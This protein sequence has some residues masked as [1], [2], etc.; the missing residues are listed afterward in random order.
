MI[1]ANEGSPLLED[2]QSV[3]YMILVNAECP[4]AVYRPESVAA[5]V[6]M[7][8]PFPHPTSLVRP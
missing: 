7:H 2:F 3:Q 1:A 5:A 8:E 6:F 4:Y